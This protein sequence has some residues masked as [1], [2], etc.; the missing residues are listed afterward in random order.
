M[1]AITVSN[2]SKSYLIYNS[3]SDRIRETF[4][5]VRKK[6]RH[7]K[8]YSLRDVSFDVNTGETVGIIGQNGAGKSSLLKIITGVATP[9]S[10]SVDVKGRVS[11][12]LEL[13]AGFNQQFTGIENI[14]LNGTIRGFS[15]AEIEQRIP[16]ILDFADIG[17]FAN[18]PVKTYSSGMF[19]RLAFA[20]AINVEPDILIVDEALSVGDAAFQAKCFHKFE[21]LKQRGITIL[22]VSH[23]ISAIKR[24]CNRVLWLKNG[25]VMDFG[26]KR[27]ICARYYNEILEKNNRN[28]ANKPKQTLPVPAQGAETSV[29]P[30]AAAQRPAMV[31]H[32]NPVEEADYPLLPDEIERGGTGQARVLSCFV[33]DAKGE[34]TM[35][36]D[37]DGRYTFH[38]VGEFYEPVEQ[39]IL[40]LVFED[41]RGI[42]VFY[43]NNCDQPTAFD[44]DEPGVY[45]MV[46]SVRLPRLLRGEYLISPSVASG[47]QTEN[48]SLDWAHNAL[49]L[50]V[51]NPGYNLAMLEV[52]PAAIDVQRIE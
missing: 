15:R 25:Q 12:L 46:F 33:R 41:P 43:L 42:A 32:E 7:Q 17:D 1:K 20:V 35:A 8:F 29:V 49:T 28:M 45:E 16:A 31:V 39:A 4:S 18:H 37:V 21:E 47:T 36:L 30:E 19:A 22:F 51:H 40:G 3:P 11:A 23:D 38:V 27:T 5:F 26:D 13:G 48:I 9:S 2:V 52:V 6:Q 14:F 24:M 44:V 50:S 10:G 34:I